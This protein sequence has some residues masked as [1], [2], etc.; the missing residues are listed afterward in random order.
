M[1]W[2]S[3]T[4]CAQ[5]VK[6]PPTI[7]CS[8][9]GDENY[10]GRMNLEEVNPILTAWASEYV[11][12]GSKFV[13]CRSDPC[14]NGGIPE[15]GEDGIQRCR[16]PKHYAGKYC[17]YCS[18]YL[19]SR[20]PLIMGLVKYSSDRTRFMLRIRGEN[21]HLLAFVGVA[22]KM[23]ALIY[24]QF[25]Y[26]RRVLVVEQDH[27]GV[28]TVHTSPV[29]RQLHCGTSEYDSFWIDH[30]EGYF[31]IGFQGNST[32]FMKVRPKVQVKIRSIE[33]KVVLPPGAHWMIELPCDYLVL[34]RKRAT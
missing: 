14:K 3:V 6:T 4:G 24:I 28:H 30:S 21:G 8:N 10:L 20:E 26:Q 7:F 2:H 23:E 32:P 15:T 1:L 17:Q 9:G 31:Q 25:C 12:P 16:C 34:K 27:G 13:A 11:S 18:F 33:L 29:L 22:N 5:G 19:E